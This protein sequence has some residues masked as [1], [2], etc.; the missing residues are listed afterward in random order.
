MNN[1]SSFFRH[2]ATSIVV[3]VLCF[4]ALQS[5]AQTTYR[6]HLKTA[7]GFL[8]ATILLDPVNDIATIHDWNFST[9]AT[10]PTIV[11][12]DGFMIDNERFPLLFTHMDG[13]T[14]EVLYLVHNQLYADEITFEIF[15]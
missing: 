10:Y 6:G 2:L 13:Y 11:G 14:Y 15:D 1:V 7:N 5:C 3:G 12:T 4:C 8:D 9:T